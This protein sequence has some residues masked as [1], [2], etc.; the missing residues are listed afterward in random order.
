L[1]G[2]SDRP[3]Y[4]QMGQVSGMLALTLYCNSAL[5]EKRAKDTAYQNTD[6]WSQGE[7]F[8]YRD[9]GKVRQRV[10]ALAGPVKSK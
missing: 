4:V 9:D 10:W 2:C 5:L 8:D 3:Q 1:L 7:L 6:V